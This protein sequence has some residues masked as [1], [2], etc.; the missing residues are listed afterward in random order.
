[1]SSE[2]RVEI[3]KQFFKDLEEGKG[4]EVVLPVCTEGAFFKCDVF[5]QKTI[6]EYSEFMKGLYSV[7]PDFK[8]EILSVTSNDTEVTFVANMTGTHVSGGPVPPSDPPKSTSGMYVYVVYIGQDNKV[9]GMLKVF[10]IHTA[11]SK[12]GWPY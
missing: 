3:A 7:I 11:F 5:P 9:S 12:L 2:S 1:M 6:E 8:Y 4:K 10:D